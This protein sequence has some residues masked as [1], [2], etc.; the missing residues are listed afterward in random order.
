VDLLQ[1]V[2]SVHSSL[3]TA[4]NSSPTSH[5]GKPNE[6]Q[7]ELL[8]KGMETIIGVLGNVIK[9]FDEKVSH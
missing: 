1:K 2:N 8:T 4:L 7:V 6:E 5:T 9:G 3:K